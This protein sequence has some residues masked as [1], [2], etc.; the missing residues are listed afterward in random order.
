M[1]QS[2]ILPDKTQKIYIFLYNL[3]AVNCNQG[4]VTQFAPLTLASLRLWELFYPYCSDI[5]VLGKWATG[6]QTEVYYSFLSLFFLSIEYPKRQPQQANAMP[7]PIPTPIPDVPKIFEKTVPHNT[8]ITI[9]NR[10]PNS[11]VYLYFIIFTTSTTYSL[12]K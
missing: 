6:G 2:G 12:L 7:N 10:I 4:C 8:L 5:C 11:T 3:G 1:Y 9:P